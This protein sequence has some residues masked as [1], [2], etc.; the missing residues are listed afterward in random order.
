MV[1]GTQISASWERMTMPPPQTG[2]LDSPIDLTEYG[3]LPGT[4][5][6]CSSSSNPL[7]GCFAWTNTTVTGEVHQNNGCLGL[8]TNNSV[9]AKA[10]HGKITS[11]SRGWTELTN[12]TCGIDNLRLYCFEQSTANP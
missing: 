8:T 7:Q 5:M 4:S 3:D 1:D 12:F 9:F 2:Y 10:A 6:Q 11:V